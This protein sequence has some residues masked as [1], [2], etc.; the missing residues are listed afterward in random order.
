MDVDVDED[1]TPFNVTFQS[2]ADGSPD[3]V[4][5]TEYVTRLNVTVSLTV[6]PLT[7]KDPPCAE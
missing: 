5:V 6:P 4:K 1:F 3:S 2:E 7:V